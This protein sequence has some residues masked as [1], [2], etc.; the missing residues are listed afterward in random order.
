MAA[1]QGRPR[2]LKPSYQTFAFFWPW[3]L[4]IALFSWR[5]EMWVLILG[6]GFCLGY[7]WAYLRIFKQMDQVFG[8]ETADKIWTIFRGY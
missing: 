1:I 7:V 3:V 4:L 6:L 8:K 2:L 5:P